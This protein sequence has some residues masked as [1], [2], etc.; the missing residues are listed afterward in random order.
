M[1]GF[2]TKA[3]RMLRWCRLQR[4]GELRIFMAGQNSWP[5]VS[6][7]DTTWYNLAE[8]PQEMAILT[9]KNLESRDSGI[10]FGG[11]RNTKILNLEVL[12]LVLLKLIHCHASR[13][14]HP[15][16]CTLQNDGFGHSMKVV[17]KNCFVSKL[18][19]SHDLLFVQLIGFP[20][21]SRS[22]PPKNWKLSPVM[23][24]YQQ[25]NEHVISGIPPHWDP[26]I[27]RFNP[28]P[29]QPWFGLVVREA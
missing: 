29:K 19:A 3:V 21:A 12:L 15:K 8:W 4:L 6:F 7:N 10:V 9:N 13:L 16:D 26:Y 23:V 1:V 27:L 24:H 22:S 28:G 18:R 20:C 2:S 17:P 5:C 25:K 14:G 11:K